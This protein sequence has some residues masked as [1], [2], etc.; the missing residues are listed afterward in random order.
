MLKL[1]PLKP[2]S[3]QML[4]LDALRIVGA[5]MIV[6]FHFN[7]FINL[8]GRWQAADDTIKSFSLIVDL[9]FLISGYVMAAIYTGKLT[10]LAKYGDFL[11]KRV[12]RL[13]PL[14]W[15]TLGVFVV[16]AA[17]GWAGVI[18]ERDPSRYD[19]ACIVPNLVFVH[20][21]GTCKAQTWNFVS[22][23]ISAEM[24]LYIALPL[25]F[26]IT[27]RGRWATAAVAVGSLALLVWITRD[28]ESFSQ[29][30]YDFGVARAVPG[31]M[32]GMLAWQAR[33]TLARLPFARI[34]MWAL[35]GVFMAASW[36]GA[37]RTVLL[38]VIYAVGLAGVAADAQGV[39][40]GVS[41]R[42]APWAQ[43]SFSLYLLH[44]IALKIALN[45]VGFS[46][47]RLDGDAMRLWC[48]FW[49]VALFPIAYLSLVA[50]ERPARDRLAKWGKR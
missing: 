20:A 39:Q 15:A 44:P 31:F 3:D 5:V 7:R 11:R 1:P 17:L 30:T 13:G 36:A 33:D 10:T 32:L 9:F 25:L 22:W 23:A 37:S 12:A 19:V 46:A 34:V 43:L 50:F 40:G 29:W 35:L 16:I 45:W 41:R 8:D 14:H 26:W 38:L 24:G 21:W 42:L 27:A 18:S 6:V 47:W 28:G 2:D 4:H 49:V 48:L